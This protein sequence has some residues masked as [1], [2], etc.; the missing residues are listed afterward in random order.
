MRGIYFWFLFLGLVLVYFLFLSFNL[1]A[2]PLYLDEGLYIFWASL[3]KQDPGLAYVSMQDGKTPFFIW[4]TQLLNPLFNDYLFTGRII[5]VLASAVTLISSSLIAFKI[6]GRK[7]AVFTGLLFLVTPFSIL[8]SRMAFVDSLLIAFGTLSLLL[9]YLVKESAEKKKI[10][11]SLV[12]AVFSGL[13]LGLAFLTKTTARIFLVTE[14]LILVF[15]IYESFKQRRLKQSLL[16]LSAIPIIL[17][18][19]FEILG[20]LRFGAIRFWDMIANKE[21]DLIF[22]LP[23][24]FNNLTGQGAAYIYFRNLPFYFEYL[25]IYFGVILILFFA[26]AFKLLKDKKHFWLFIT[27]AVFSFGVVLSAKIPA[28]RYFAITIPVI[29][30]ISSIG[31]D[32]IW[33]KKQRVLKVGAVFIL[34]VG[35]Y[36]SSKIIISPQNAFYSSDDRSYFIESEINA[37]GLNEIIEFLEP[38]KENSIVGIEA[39]W[40]VSEG[41]RTVLEEKG[42]QNEKLD[43]IIPNQGSEDF[44]CEDGYISD[45]KCWKANLESL[46]KN[47]KPQKFV[48]L[49]ATEDRIEFLKKLANISIIKEFRRPGAGI[50]S[51]LIQLNN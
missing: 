21:G 35:F 12:F 5:S 7:A 39:T 14:I 18:I 2:L 10:Y 41:M 25:F 51:Y 29:L 9:L 4:I 11:Q 1:L 50:T 36:F 47:P 22:S 20:Y 44:K 45:N 48:Y 26:G 37:F 13:F 38:Q 32:W 27:L 6:S 49:T 16:L 43:H 42:I 8:I 46:R 31:F 33:G 17:G 23:E 30:I 28:S 19:Y 15:W 34:M 3:F 24:I 40:G